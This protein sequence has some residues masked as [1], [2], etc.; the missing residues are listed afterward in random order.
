MLK[1]CWSSCVQY[2]AMELHFTTTAI[3]RGKLTEDIKKL[4]LVCYATARNFL[5]Q[6]TTS[7]PIATA[8]GD[9]TEMKIYCTNVDVY[10]AV[11]KLYSKI[12]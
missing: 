9:R 3:F 1:Y 11:Q 10:C 7:L 6:S 4:H 2:D 5:R 8:V 12:R